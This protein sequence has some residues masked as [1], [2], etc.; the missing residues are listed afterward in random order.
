MAER[1][2]LAQPV[3]SGQNGWVWKLFYNYN[4][5]FLNYFNYNQ[6]LERLSAN[7]FTIIINYFLSYDRDGGGD[8]WDLDDVEEVWKTNQ[9]IAMGKSVRY[10]EQRV[11]NNCAE[12]RL[13]FPHLSQSSSSSLIIIIIIIP[14][15]HH[16][17]SPLSSQHP[18]FIINLHHRDLH[19]LTITRAATLAA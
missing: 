11:S 3:P 14:P 6:L 8:D 18:N 15:P 10:L 4:Q 7:S 13:A 12:E 9:C 2:P 16:Y 17:S 19:N 5:L 1:K